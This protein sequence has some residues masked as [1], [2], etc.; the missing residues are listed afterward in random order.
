[1][2]LGFESEKCKQCFACTSYEQKET[3]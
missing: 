1:M 3:L 2:C